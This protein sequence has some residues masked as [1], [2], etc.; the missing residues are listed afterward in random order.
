LRAGCTP[1]I[2]ADVE[3]RDLVTAA[4]LPWAEQTAL[5]ALDSTVL[6]SIAHLP[7]A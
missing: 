3:Y 6:R 5:L 7:L 2:K 1:K 4:L